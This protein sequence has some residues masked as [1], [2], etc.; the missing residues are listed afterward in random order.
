MNDDFILRSS[1]ELTSQ[2]K[3]IKKIKKENKTK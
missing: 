3:K 2:E 1:F